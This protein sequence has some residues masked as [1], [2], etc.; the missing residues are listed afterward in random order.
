MEGISK[1]FSGVKVLSG[2]NFEL[3]AGEVHVLAGEN[4]AGKSTLIK[5]LAG[6]HAADEGVIRIDGDPVRFRSPHEAWRRGI[7]VIHQ[8]SSLIG[9]MS[10]VDNIFLGREYC[11]AGGLLQRER[12]NARA[13]VLLAEFDLTIDV[14]LPVEDFPLATR[15]MIEIAKAIAFDARVIVMDE[16]TSALNGPEV[17]RLFSIIASL[18]N[19]GCG[20]IY[21]S[22]KMEEIYTVADR[23]S[24]L[25]DG[26]SVGT[27]AVADLPKAD[28]IR[29]MVGRELNQ[30]FPRKSGVPGGEMMVFD[31]VSVFPPPGLASTAVRDVSF[32]LKKGEILGIAGLQGSGDSEL[33][34]GVFGT[35]G[36]CVEGSISIGGRPFVPG[37]PGLS[38][39]Q[40][41]ALMTNDRK[42][43]GLVWGMNLVANVTLAALKKFSPAGW[44]RPTREAATANER[45]SSLKLRYSSL[46]QD[47]MELSGGNQQKVILARWLETSPSVLFLDEPTRGVDVG[48]KHEI[49]ELMNRLTESGCAIVLITSE[50]PELLAMADRV[51]V[52]SGGRLV[53]EF[54]KQEATQERILHSAM[55]EAHHAANVA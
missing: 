37:S 30:Q 25:R 49:Y 11:M 16:P 43:S 20:I 6:V 27:A 23:I 28:L 4:G 32:V 15:Q 7:A 31:H 13:T 12:Q 51:L 18:K 29:W 26:L 38:L 17:E 1:S 55:K 54:S 45:F 10:V 19:R 3:R 52:M 24:V 33:L 39:D 53:A 2:V 47:V 48:V 14:S 8:E 21:I 9:P 46:D 40:G 5:I 22:H 44:L 34:N 36:P 42:E 50:M 41:L 35:Y